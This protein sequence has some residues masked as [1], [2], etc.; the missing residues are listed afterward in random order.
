MPFTFKRDK[1]NKIFVQINYDLEF[2]ACLFGLKSIRYRD[3]KGYLK[4]CQVL[5][6]EYKLTD[7]N[8]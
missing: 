3:L 8:K 7:N 6:W 2:Y 4:Y 5:D 1:F